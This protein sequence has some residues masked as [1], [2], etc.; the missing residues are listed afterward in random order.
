[1]EMK[2]TNTYKDIRVSYII[3]TLSLLHVD[4]SSTRVAILREVFFVGVCNLHNLVIY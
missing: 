1:M 2:P 3:N 4:V